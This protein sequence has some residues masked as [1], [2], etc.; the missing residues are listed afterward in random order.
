MSYYLDLA[1]KMD[2]IASHDPKALALL[3]ESAAAL[4]D[5]YEKKVFAEKQ[6]ARISEARD[7]L[8]R[9]ITSLQSPS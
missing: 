2:R 9:E 5:C 1:A 6:A 7:L 3:R 8:L 4:R